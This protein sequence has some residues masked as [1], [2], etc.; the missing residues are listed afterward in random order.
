M[1]LVVQLPPANTPKERGRASNRNKVKL[2]NPVLDVS[3][4]PFTNMVDRRD[5]RAHTTT[6]TTTST[7][8]AN[9]CAELTLVGGDNK[10]PT[11]LRWFQDGTSKEVAMLM[12]PPSSDLNKYLWL[13]HGEH[14]G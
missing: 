1:N 12:T 11:T 3:F 4:G 5:Q 6:Q 10:R 9:P 7:I 2:A 13:S 8:T 14:L